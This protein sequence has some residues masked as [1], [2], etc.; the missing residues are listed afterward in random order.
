M[1]K[2]KIALTRLN[3]RVEKKK[4]IEGIIRNEVTKEYLRRSQKDTITNKNK[5]KIIQYRIIETP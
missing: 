1:A 5:N 2:I 4:K 3:I